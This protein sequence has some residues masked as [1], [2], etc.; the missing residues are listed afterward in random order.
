LDKELVRC[1]APKF[2]LLTRSFIF[3]A[4]VKDMSL[5]W[6]AHTLYFPICKK[7]CDLIPGRILSL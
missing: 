5:Q 3:K 4:L 1:K 2:L 7:R 6:T